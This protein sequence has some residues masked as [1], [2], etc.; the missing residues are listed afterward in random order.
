MAGHWGWEGQ[1]LW[2][3]S[4]FACLVFPLQSFLPFLAPPSEPLPVSF[5]STAPLGDCGVLGA[6]HVLVVPAKGVA[7]RGSSAPPPSQAAFALP[8]CVWLLCAGFGGWLQPPFP[9]AGVARSEQSQASCSFP[10]HPSSIPP[11]MGSRRLPGSLAPWWQCCSPVVSDEEEEQ[12]LSRCE[13]QQG[14][15]G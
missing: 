7:G 9:F 13:G 11:Q 10:A 2:S 12:G 5:F 15:A 14:R 1:G 4:C 6:L 8:V 3:C